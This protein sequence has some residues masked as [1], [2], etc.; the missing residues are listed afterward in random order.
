MRKRIKSNQITFAC[1]G[2]LF[3]RKDNSTVVAKLQV[4]YNNVLVKCETGSYESEEDYQDVLSI[5]MQIEKLKQNHKKISK[6]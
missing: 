3:I 2:D 5:R 1:Q 4:K 6:L